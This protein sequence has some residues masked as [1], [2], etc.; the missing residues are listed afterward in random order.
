L[1]I[2]VNV[3][4]G[5]TFEADAAVLAH[6]QR[7]NF[8]RHLRKYSTAES[9]FLAAEVIYGE[10][11][12]NVIRH[13]NGRIRIA[14]EWISIH[15]VL[16]VRDYGNGFRHSFELPHDMSETGRGLHMVRS[17]AYD[18]EIECVPEG[19]EVRAVLPVN[20]GSVIRY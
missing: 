7:S 16:K 3:T 15:P 10:L 9:D 12:A 2:D 11:V 1:Q 6:S 13:A 4:R 8:M 14:L 20:N 18:L 19:C 5:W 17:L